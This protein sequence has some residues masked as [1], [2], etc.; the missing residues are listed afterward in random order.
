MHFKRTDPSYSWRHS[1]LIRSWRISILCTTFYG[2]A[3][4]GFAKRSTRHRCC[5][6]GYGYRRRQR[7]G[8]EWSA[9]FRKEEFQGERGELVSCFCIKLKQLPWWWQKWV[10]WHKPWVRD[11]ILHFC[12]SKFIKYSITL[13]TCIM[14]A[15]LNFIVGGQIWKAIQK[16]QEWVSCCRRNYDPLLAE[17]ISFATGCSIIVFLYIRFSLGHFHNGAHL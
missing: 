5:F 13:S 15:F 12:R 4:A 14:P 1:L 2:F 8:V 9:V 6:L 7:S 17:D 3:V 11:W 10:K 16:S